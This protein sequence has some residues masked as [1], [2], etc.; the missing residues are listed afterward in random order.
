MRKPRVAQISIFEK[1]SQHEL[2]IQLE[3]PS[4]I[5]DRYPEILDLIK[6][7]LIGSLCKKVGSD[8]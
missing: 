1:Y 7:D 5:L 6:S 2:D 8:G 4:N 3:Q